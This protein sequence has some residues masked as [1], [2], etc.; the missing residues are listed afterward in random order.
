MAATEPE[1]LS[2]KTK[3]IPLKESHH[4]L[5]KLGLGFWIFVVLV[6]SF[7]FM[8]IFYLQEIIKLAVSGYGYLGIF[9]M[10]FITDILVQPVGPD[11]PLVFGL[12]TESF[13]PLLVLALVLLGSY[14]ALFVAYYIG[15]DIG[16]AGIEKMVGTLTYQKLLKSPSYGLWILFLGALTPIPYVPYF[17]GLWHLSFRD[18]LIYAVVPRTIRLVAV[19]LLAYYLGTE[20]FHIV[21]F[22]STT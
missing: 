3:D 13:N 15:R 17:A 14:L 16:A 8:F 11:V 6:F 22:G 18:V 19:F 7:G 9:V 10:S 5:Q 2:Q 1:E 20:V 12:F 4:L 21:I